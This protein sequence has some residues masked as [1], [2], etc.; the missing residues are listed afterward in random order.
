MSTD[1]KWRSEAAQSVAEWLNGRALGG[2]DDA[3]EA[4]GLPAEFENDS[5]FCAALDQ[6]IFVCDGCGW[7]CG[8]DEESSEDG[9]C[10]GCVH[11][12]DEEDDE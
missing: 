8:R 1:D 3:L 6:H 4:L 10:D 9:Y 11:E 5:E 12:D 2:I 7:W